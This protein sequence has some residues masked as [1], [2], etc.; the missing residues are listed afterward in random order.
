MTSSEIGK[1]VLRISIQKLKNFSQSLTS[2]L[3]GF[4]EIIKTTQD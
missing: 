4:A 2:I 1:V 3:R